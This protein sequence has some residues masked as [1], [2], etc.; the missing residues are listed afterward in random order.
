MVNYIYVI[1]DE[2]TNAVK[3]G[4]SNDPIRRLSSLQTA[5][6]KT[7]L[8]LLTIFQGDKDIESAIHI[9]LEEYKLQ[10]EW[11]DFNKDVK[12]YLIK[13]QTNIYNNII[14]SKS[15]IFKNR[16]RDLCDIY[17]SEYKTKKKT[18]I[19]M[20]FL[21]DSLSDF[22][23]ITSTTIRHTMIELGYYET[24]NNTRSVFF[25]KVNNEN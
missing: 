8:K 1:I 12:D 20:R 7:T 18:K 22:S 3:I 11:F 19:P 9:D 16:V 21:K 10:G 5:H 23:D 17:L 14:V 24:R 25:S 6:S 13:A 4:Y 15:S 2:T